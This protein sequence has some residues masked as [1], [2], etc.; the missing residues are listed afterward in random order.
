MAEKW[1]LNKIKNGLER[2][3]EENGRLPT[4]PEIDNL[5]YLPSARQIQRRFGG[6][7]KLR[8]DLGYQDVHFGK[9]KYRS[10]IA[11]R[12]NIRGRHTELALEKILVEK[13]GEVF[14][15]TERIFDQSKNR[16]DF[17]VYTPDGNFGIDVF[18]TDTMRDLQQNINIKINKYKHFPCK[19]Y[20]V[21]GNEIFTQDQLD[22]Y[23]SVKTKALPPNT[24]IVSLPT[25]FREINIYRRWANPINAL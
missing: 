19:L 15:H 20:L 25:M 13:F 9:G 22:N 8:A 12:A 11:S 10:K 5:E 18:W 17:Y 1:D 7:E 6:L 3:N 16:V 14:V 4:A 23:A 21:V 2:F 24:F